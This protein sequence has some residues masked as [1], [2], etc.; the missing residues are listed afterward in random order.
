MLAFTITHTISLPINVI[1]ALLTGV[2]IQGCGSILFRLSHVL[3]DNLGVNT[4]Y[5]AT[6]A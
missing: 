4:I 6:H 2:F 3:T 5:Y 1:T